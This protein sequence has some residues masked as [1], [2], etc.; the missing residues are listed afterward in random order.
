MTRLGPLRLFALAG[1]GLAG[2]DML[3]LQGRS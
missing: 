1:P 3:S 2:W